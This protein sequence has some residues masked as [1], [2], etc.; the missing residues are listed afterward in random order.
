M[1][2]AHLKII[3]TYLTGIGN[4][5][6]FIPVLRALR[7]QLPE[8]TIDVLVRDVASRDILERVKCANTIELFNPG[9]LSLGEKF[10]FLRRLRQQRYDANLTAFPSNRAEF[11]IL[12]FLIGAKRRIATAYEV[13]AFETLAF[14]QTD[15]VQA[16]VNRHEIDQNF[17]LLS[18]LGITNSFAER[19]RS[20]QLQAAE[21]EA[22]ADFLRQANVP[23]NARLIG[24]HPGCNPEQ[25]NIYKRWPAEHFAALGDRLIQE[26][27]VQLIGFGGPAEQPLLQEIQRRMHQKLLLHPVTS[28]LDTAAV[29]KRCRLFVSNDSGMMHIAAALN[30]PTVGLFGPSNPNRSAPPGNQHFVI[31][32]QLPCVPCNTYP[33]YQYGGSYVRCIYKGAQKG[34][35]MQTLPV[36]RVYDA[37][38]KNYAAHLRP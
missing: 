31:Q 12:S 13:G 10:R 5:V 22:A 21:I 4:A 16:D 35:C 6:L 23:E 7:Q 33:H 26:F 9:Q 8:A 14:L 38:V 3:I 25:G 20:F 2:S 32:A 37:I 18:P 1:N 19:D 27:G 24:F 15:R 29:L 17:A 30:V 36:D 28:I 34:Y 11:N